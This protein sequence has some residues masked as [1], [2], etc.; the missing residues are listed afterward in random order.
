M[1]GRGG[2][3]HTCTRVRA[4]T[5]ASIPEG[6]SRQAGSL[7]QDTLELGASEGEGQ[8]DTAHQQ[9]TAG[10]GFEI[11]LFDS[12]F[13]DLESVQYLRLWSPEQ[14]SGLYAGS[15]IRRFRVRD[16]LGSDTQASFL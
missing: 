15:R 5:L 8:A 12:D 2:R 6:I 10:R 11:S 14:R 7:R 4:R 9:R 13:Y 16:P 1:G 3:I